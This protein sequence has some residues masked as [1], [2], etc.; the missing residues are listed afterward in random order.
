MRQSELNRF[1]CEA[2]GESR[3][4]VARL[5]WILSDPDETFDDPH[6]EKLGPWVFDFD[7]DPHD[8]KFMNAKLPL[9]IIFA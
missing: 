4:T 5:G 3:R 2:T 9:D 8:P 7:G 6:D 1:V